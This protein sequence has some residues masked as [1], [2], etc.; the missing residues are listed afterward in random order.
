MS[1][2][3]FYIS[4]VNCPLHVEEIADALYKR[5]DVSMYYVMVTKH[6]ASNNIYT[7]IAIEYNIFISHHDIHRKFTLHIG[8]I[9]CV[10]SSIQGID[11][12]D[13]WRNL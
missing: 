13:E 3:K 12:N 5:Q 8:E 2:K 4:F 7:N 9:L 11:D 6:N 1:S 10:P